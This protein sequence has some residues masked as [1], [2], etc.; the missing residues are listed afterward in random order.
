MLAF[1]SDFVS[2]VKFLR[3]HKSEQL[4]AYRRANYT[5]SEQYLCAID[6]KINK[7]P[8]DPQSNLLPQ[9]D[10]DI[11]L[12]ALA[13]QKDPFRTKALT[14]LKKLSFQNLKQKELNFITY[15]L[16]EQISNI[17][18]KGEEFSYKDR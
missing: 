4:Y 17:Y 16:T 3:T 9:F 2:E 8:K 15:H 13:F 7:I 5:E 11:F 10:I 12:Y 18:I 6:D 14:G 1:V